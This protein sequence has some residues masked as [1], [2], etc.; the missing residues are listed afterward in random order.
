LG[1]KSV[2]R[3]HKEGKG[4]WMVAQQGPGLRRW[5]KKAEKGGI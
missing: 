5:K 4:K 1:E 3:S 2:M